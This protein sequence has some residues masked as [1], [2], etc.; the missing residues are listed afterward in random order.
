MW[1][2]IR[3]I[4]IKEFRQAL[5]E[6]RMRIVL[7]LP[8]IIQLVIF[9]FAVNL[10]VT[11]AKMGWMDLDRTPVSR[12]LREAFE[13]SPNFRL[14]EYPRNDQETRNLLDRGDVMAI[15]RVLPGF[16][17]DVKRGDT[18]AVQILVEG[19]NSNTASLI[20]SYAVQVVG[21]FAAARLNEVQR[22]WMVA[23]TRVTGT[24]LNLA[25]P[26]LD[27]RRR[28]WFNSDLK[29]RNYFVPGVLV[30]IIAM[31]TV[32]LTAM[33]IVREK[34]IGTMEQLM[35]TPIRP[36]E[37]MLGKT[38]PF[39]IVGLVQVSVMTGLALLVFQVPFRGN[40]F[41]LL[42]SAAIFLL[43]TLGAG[44]FISTIS[45]TQQQAMMT[46]F[47]IFVPMFLLSGFSFPINSM[48]VLVQ[49]VTYLNP[50]R[51]F[52]EIIRGIFLKGIGIRILWPQVL[53]L[54]GYGVLIL[55]ASALRFQKK[56]D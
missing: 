11:D 41:F 6:P 17:K 2:R 18:S 9:G 45:H 21:R 50:L 31:V 28:V 55:V 34:E 27:V 29:S 33:S 14:T 19:S 56:L 20:S 1:E 23:P 24:A 3:V 30:N 16:G 38:L 12:E 22:Q 40:F 25:I 42:G 36:M 44:L 48:P 43:T 37:L 53:A 32:M 39:A 52:V 7:F 10:D 4:V 54:G 15:V 13:A 5:R 26:K 47:F 35:V 46:F 8:P 51:Y 49:Y